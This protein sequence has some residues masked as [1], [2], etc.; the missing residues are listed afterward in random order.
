MERVTVDIMGP[1]PVTKFGNRY[2]LV[3]TNWFTK[4]TEC[5]NTRPRGKTIAEAVIN[6]FVVSF[7]VPLQIYTDQCRNFKSTLF[8]E[9]CNYLNIEKTHSS[10]M[11]PQANGLVERS[12]RTFTAM[13]SKYC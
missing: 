4:W 9:L 10:S 6:N 3:T 13:L 12:N 8:S 5:P 1:L 11:R 2:N 7:G